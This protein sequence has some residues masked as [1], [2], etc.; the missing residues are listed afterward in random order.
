[1][2]GGKRKTG[3]MLLSRRSMLTALGDWADLN[4]PL[5]GPPFY[6]FE[7]ARM[8]LEERAEGFDARFGTDTSSPFLGRDPKPASHFY[9]PTTGSVIYEIL[10][11]LPLEPNAFSFVD[12]GSGKGRA[13]LVASEFPFANII[14]VE[15]S[16]H[17]H[18]IAEEN[19]RRYLPE[20]QQ[21][22]TF[23]LHCMD[24][25][26]YVFGPEPVVLFLFD[27]FS[28]EILCRVLANL[29]DS[30]KAAPREVFVVY[31]YPQ[32]EALLRKSSCLKLISKGGPRWRPWSAYVIYGTTAKH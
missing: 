27:P 6:L 21:C 31:V 12:L 30:L 9:V 5:L 18:Q 4:G 16:A 10:A 7:G 19:V 14:G 17:L 13:M 15:L 11:K 23:S 20:S 24:A 29:E 8:Y 1:V 32:F 26:D 25:L 22:K 28:E 3:G 2:D